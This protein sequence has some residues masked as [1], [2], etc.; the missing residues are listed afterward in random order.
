MEPRDAI[1]GSVVGVASTFWI[2][3]LKTRIQSGRNVN[4]PL[5]RGLAPF[6]IASTCEKATKLVV[7]DFTRKRCNNAAAS[8]VTACIQTS[9]ITPI[10]AVKIRQQHG[11]AHALCVVR[12]L[13]VGGLYRGALATVLRDA[14]YNA[15][16]FG[17]HRRDVPITGFAAAATAAIIATPADVVKTRIQLADERPKNISRAVK[18]LWFQKG[19]RGFFAGAPQR[20]IS[21]GLLYG[22][23]L[24][25]CNASWSTK[26][27]DPVGSG[28]P[29]GT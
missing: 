20:A 28:T 3:T 24:G 26:R 12:E 16:L 17:L 9:M 15:I 29:R 19:M 14:P 11:N 7:Y 5:T 1:I 4:A 18:E 6:L 21:Q 22:I 10:E 25:I 27:R 8:V 23:A 2:D 13:G